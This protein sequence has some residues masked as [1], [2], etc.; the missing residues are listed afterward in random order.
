MILRK[1]SKGFTLLETLV[2]IAIIGLIGSVVFVSLN[3]ARRKG[4]DAKRKIEISQIAR[5]FSISCYIPNA[6]PGEYDIIELVPE[7]ITQYPQYAEYA[8]RIPKDPR[9]GTDTESKYIYTVNTVGK[10]AIFANLENENELVTLPTLTYPTAGGGTGV[11]EATSSGW[12][13]T[14]KYFQV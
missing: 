6:G 1:K 5:F 14:H 8:N 9:S 2:V 11:L 10:C 12:N 3:N 13:G 7:L 4:A